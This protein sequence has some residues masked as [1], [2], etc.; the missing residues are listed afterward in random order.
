MIV[1]AHVIIFSQ[2]APA[3]RAFLRDV[4]GLASKDAGGG[5]P[6]FALPPTE[7]AVHPGEESGNHELF[8]ITDD[9]AS[10]VASLRA[11]GIQ[12]SEVQEPAWGSVTRV[13]LPGGG[14]VALYQPKLPVAL[15]RTQP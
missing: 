14:D 8:L 3:D 13:P 10:E 11:R 1:G 7:V 15:T 4:L 9:L 6:V 2:D 12:C 5:W